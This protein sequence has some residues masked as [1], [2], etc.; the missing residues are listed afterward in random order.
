M[1]RSPEREVKLQVGPSFR[2]PDLDAV[3][4][5]LRA[6]AP[7]P[8]R[9]ETAYWD[10]RD[11]RLARWGL[12]LRYRA[13]EG[14]TL[15]LPSVG[16]GT[17]L[18][19]EELTFRGSA[20]SVPA[21][22]N[23]LVRAYVRG[24]TLA[25]VARLS[26]LRRRVS[27]V[28][29]QDLQ[30]LEVVDDEVSVRDGR[31]VTAR[32][33]EI[34]VEL[35]DGGEEVLEAVLERLRKAGAGAPDPTPKYV[36]ALGPMAVQP[37]EVSEVPTS[38]QPSASAVITNALASSVATILRHDPGIR[39]GGDPEDVHRARVGTR[40]L[41]SNLRTFRPLLEP[42]WTDS[43]RDELS[44]LGGELGTLR[45]REV[46]LDRL[47]GRMHRLPADPRAQA[48]LTADLERAVEEARQALL[49]ALGSQRYVGLLD[50]LVAAG[51]RPDVL[52]A[53]RHPAAEVLPPL[54][55]KPWRKLRKAARALTPESSDEELHRSRI[56]AKRARY[57]AEAVTA[58]AP[59]ADRFARAAARLQTV[60]GEHQDSVTARAWLQAH[61]GNGRRAF[62]A[63]E[64]AG[65]EVSAA[66]AARGELPSTWAALDR[67]RLRRWMTP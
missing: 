34:E 53:A 11:L 55:R 13:S 12:S 60:L 8:T 31:R 33:R 20:R 28:D 37:P 23:S 35:K 21:P 44:W 54:A 18:K 66:E 39:L 41:R 45:D 32:F 47:R 48:A 42:E 58:A 57:A 62:L 5:G 52:E 64:L 10:T 24:E 9:L 30:M 67:K 6:H 27:V 2:L 36:R 26:T 38:P 59:D 29:G 50:R 25:P 7:E 63:G 4:E 65:L 22:A 61:A 56:L 43:L 51:A 19:R 16:E 49:T 46:L 14:W 15:K 1:P 3:R 40:R 17:L